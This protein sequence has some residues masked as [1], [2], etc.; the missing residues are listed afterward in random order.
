MNYIHDDSPF[1]PASN[2]DNGITIRAYI[3]AQ[4]L[5]NLAITDRKTQ[6]GEGSTVYDSAAFR[7]LAYADALIQQLNKEA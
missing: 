1:I 4:V 6:P 2:N 3:A 5:S 7:A